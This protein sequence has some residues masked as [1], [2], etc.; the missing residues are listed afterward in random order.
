MKEFMLRILNQVD[1][2]DSM[3]PESHQRFLQSCKD[4]IGELTKQGKLIA[5]QPLIREGKII[6]K[7]KSDWK[8]IPFNESSEVH[9]G[10]YLILADDLDDAIS[11][12]KKNPEFE[13]TSTAR[14][15]VRPIK[16]KEASTGFEYPK[17]S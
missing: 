10:Y 4:Y 2:K 6:S 8:E 16:M 15:E 1:S 12:A 17:T 13:Y 9:V 5:A 7:T 11:I 14:V 3:T